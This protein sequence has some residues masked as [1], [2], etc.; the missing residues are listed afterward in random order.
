MYEWFRKIS[1]RESTNREYSVALLSAAKVNNSVET[2][3]A[4]S[5]VLLVCWWRE[6]E[7]LLGLDRDLDREREE[8]AK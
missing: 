5:L 8:R 7:L 3:A 6:R 4:R 1:T 2:A